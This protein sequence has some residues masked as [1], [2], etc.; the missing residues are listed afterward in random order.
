[1]LSNEQRTLKD[2]E[3]LTGLFHTEFKV[4]EAKIQRVTRLGAFKSTSARPQ[5]LL[6]TPLLVEFGNISIKCLVLKQATK[7]RRSS[8]W[9]DVYISP[10]L[11]PKERSH[12]KKL[13]DDLK[14]RKALER[15]A[16]ISSM[17]RLFRVL[18]IVHLTSLVID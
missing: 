9:S 15:K 12:N 4:T 17:V 13:R 11:T 3:V 10:D 1:M 16:F 18:V 14:A 6:V 7:L 2:T 5:L 8:K